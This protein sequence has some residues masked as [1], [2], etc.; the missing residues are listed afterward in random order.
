VDEGRK[1]RILLSFQEKLFERI[2]EQYPKKP[3]AV[4]AI[5][6][7]L[8]IGV[9]A[10]YRRMRGETLLNPD[11]MR[12]LALKHNISLDE[13]AFQD[14][15]IAPFKT[16]LVSPEVFKIA[17]ENVKLYDS[18]DTTELWD[19]GV[20]DKTLNQIES[21]VHAEQFENTNDALLL[22][23]QMMEL[24]KHI[25]KVSEKGVKIRSQ[26][27]KFVISTFCPPN[28]FRSHDQRLCSY[29]ENWF[30]N[31]ISRSVSMSGSGAQSRNRYF[32]RLEKK[33]TN[34]KNRIKLIIEGE[35]DF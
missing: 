14:A 7:I 21:C 2:I 10:T 6:N 26:Q 22:C 24:F 20:M 15:D 27:S 29:T 5:Q 12:D 13:L 19:L 32:N 11:E 8:C 25:R 30:Q 28:F 17:K 35:I 9:N 1:T 33:I 3:D 34:M 31:I 4:L 23:D 16:N 18:I